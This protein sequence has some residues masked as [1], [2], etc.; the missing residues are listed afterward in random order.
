MLGVSSR[1]RRIVQ[2]ATARQPRPG[3]TADCAGCSS[4]PPR[5]LPVATLV[6]GLL[7]M[8]ARGEAQESATRAQASA[9]SADARR[10]AANALNEDQPSLALLAA[11]EAT[12]R[13]QSPETYGALLTLLTRSPHIVTRFRVADRLPRIARERRWSLGR[14]PP[15]TRPSTQS[16]RSPGERQWTAVSSGRCC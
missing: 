6:A 2:S 16:T 1:R 5:S 14:P 3:R 7:A 13:E 15:P 10:L 12:H 11:I 9:T 4:A 8:R